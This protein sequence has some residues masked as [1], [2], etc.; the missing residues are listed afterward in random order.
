L[1]QAL[2]VVQRGIS[3]FLIHHAGFKVSSGAVL[4]NEGP[5]SVAQMA[6]SVASR[7]KWGRGRVLTGP[8]ILAW[9]TQYPG[10]ASHPLDTQILKFCITHCW[11]FVSDLGGLPQNA[12]GKY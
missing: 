2:A 6:D 5:V 12:V 9:M 11:D 1:T 10:Y 4:G 7:P 8:L 3:T